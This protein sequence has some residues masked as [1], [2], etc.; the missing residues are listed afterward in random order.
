MQL[1]FEHLGCLE[2]SA[3]HCGRVSGLGA[4]EIDAGALLRPTR[5]MLFTLVLTCPSGLC[6][7]QR[8]E[9]LLIHLLLLG[10][11]QHTQGFLFKNVLT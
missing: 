5:R 3:G 10:R 2:F 1:R 7:W 11:P 9:G 8:R 6:W 4:R